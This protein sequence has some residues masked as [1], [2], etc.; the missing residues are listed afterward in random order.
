MGLRV[1][2]DVG[3]TFTDFVVFD[4]AAGGTGAFKV[5]SLPADPADA[6]V[7]GFRRLADEGADL[8]DV[9]LFVHGTT[10]ALNALLQ[11][12]GARVGLLATRGFRDV[13]QLRRL[14]LDGAPGFFVE[15]RAP[16]VPRRDIREIG[17]RILADGTEI[18]ALD[19][20][21]IARAA[22]ELVGAGC[23]ALAICFMHAYRNGEHERA[24]AALVRERHPGLHVTLSSDVWPQQ[25]E[26][27]RTQIAVINAHVAPV[28]ER[29]YERL[30][31]SLSGLG[32]RAP[33][34]STKSSGGIMSAARAAERPVETLLSG[35]ASGVVAA[36]ALGRAAG[37]DAL[38][39]FDMGGTSAD[40]GLIEDGSVRTSTENAIGD[41]P[42]IMPAVDIASIG[43]GGG[44]IAHVDASGV[45]KV[46]PRSAGA[47]PGPAC[48]GRGGT[49]PTVT[50]AY[51]VLGMIE[52]D[53]FLGGELA[54]DADAARDACGRVAKPLGL[55]A[56]EG[57]EA[58]LRVATAN[59]FASL[60]PLM[61][62]RGANPRD[63]T[64]LA[65]GGAGPTHAFY[66][67]RE[68]GFERVVIPAAPGTFCALGCLLADVRADFVRTIYAPLAELSDERLAGAFAELRTEADRWLAEERVGVETTIG[69]SA[70]MRYHGQSYEIAVGLPEPDGDGRFRERVVEAFGATY[71]RIYG[72]SDSAAPVELVNARAHLIG[73]TPKPRLAASA[74]ANGARPRVTR[75]VRYDG[76]YHDAAVYERAELPPGASL[77]GPAIVLQY[78]T[79][80]FLPPGHRLE[81]DGV[82]NLVG[83]VQR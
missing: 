34:F 26:Y 31:G 20:E 48:Y 37:H 28:M 27:E 19:P 74:A 44:S 61:A 8:G 59:M 10:I 68:V 83:G 9:S 38:V 2:V 77:P 73:A 42:V 65:Y 41:F 75:R 15:Q 12:A 40:I 57:A 6:V 4:D 69:Y 18:R 72:Y 70:D 13:L 47:D 17:A 39:A 81:V 56:E 23:E 43:A 1:G 79:T 63:F 35:P 55:D 53:R 54:L 29:Y 80:T 7:G 36:A 14:R 49:D 71:E 66:L 46:G 25:R 3:G 11:R 51:V 60:L 62:Q 58:I 67:A 76:S 22:A 50:D 32:V 82:G 64:L 30:V 33:V 52:P 21:E 24:A 45:L 78:D 5:P 16:L